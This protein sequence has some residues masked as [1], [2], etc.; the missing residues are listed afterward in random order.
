MVTIAVLT[1]AAMVAIFLS[2]QD[3]TKAMA[4]AG[5]VTSVTLPMLTFAMV[6]LTAMQNRDQIQETKQKVEEV[7]VK[8]DGRLEQFL[9]LTATS[10]RE[11][12]HAAGLKE[13]HEAGRAD[14]QEVQAARDSTPTARG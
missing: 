12:G 14:E 6:R 3:M 13:G 11:L 8:V 10:S 7:A 1:V 4:L 5:M 2:I 9:R